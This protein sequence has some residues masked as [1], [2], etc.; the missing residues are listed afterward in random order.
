MLPVPQNGRLE[1]PS[2]MCARV[3]LLAGFLNADGN[4]DLA[5]QKVATK[6]NQLERHDLEEVAQELFLVLRRSED[7][8]AVLRREVEGRHGALNGGR[9]SS[10]H[11]EQKGLRRIRST[12]VPGGGGFS[13]SRL[14]PP[15]SAPAGMMHGAGM[16]RPRSGQFGRGQFEDSGNGG[17]SEVRDLAMSAPSLH[18]P[19]NTTRPS[20]S[21]EEARH[22]VER[23]YDGKERRVRRQVMTE[24][25]RIKEDMRIQAAISSRC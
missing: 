5:P 4:M 13:G 19:W 7:K 11:G 3:P 15:R 16:L 10:H 22:M 8:L 18:S 9:M 6:L 2:E 17:V 25:G 14:P 12:E 21:E 23:L 24:L 1:S 20:L